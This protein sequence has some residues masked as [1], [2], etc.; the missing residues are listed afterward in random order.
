MLSDTCTFI[1][2]IV[3]PFV[4]DGDPGNIYKFVI[5]TSGQ[6]IV[7]EIYYHLPDARIGKLLYLMTSLEGEK[8]QAY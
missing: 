6:L 4:H 1:E 8:W 5:Y 7:L 2:E 3:D